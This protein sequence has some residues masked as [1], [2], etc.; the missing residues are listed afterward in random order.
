MS[1]PDVNIQI[2]DLYEETLMKYA[3]GQ[4]IDKDGII[5]TPKEALEHFKSKA[6]DEGFAE[7]TIDGSAEELIY[8]LKEI[9]E[10]KFYE[11]KEEK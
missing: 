2:G 4:L 1:I 9:E 10:Q 3:S 6:I 5:M 8:D 7:D 11:Y